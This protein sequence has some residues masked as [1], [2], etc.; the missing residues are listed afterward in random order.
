MSKPYTPKY[1]HVLAITS[2]LNPT[3]YTKRANKLYRFRDGLAHEIHTLLNIPLSA[4]RRPVLGYRIIRIVQNALTRALRREEP[5]LIK[6]FG[7]FRV[8]ERQCVKKRGG[9]I[10]GHPIVISELPVRYPKR[11]KVVF[12]AAESLRAAMNAETPSWKEKRHL[13][14]WEPKVK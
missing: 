10:V 3:S 8:V 12:V 11:K 7:K 4:N 9:I 2:A 14:R 5:I 1:A 6:G 13:S